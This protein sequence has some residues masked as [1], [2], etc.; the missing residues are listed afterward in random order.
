MIRMTTDYLSKNSTRQKTVGFIFQPET[1]QTKTGM[2]NGT[3]VFK[4]VDIKN[5]K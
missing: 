4:T 1:T 3:M 2:M 5:G